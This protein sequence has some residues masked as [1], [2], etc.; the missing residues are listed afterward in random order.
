MEELVQFIEQTP[1]ASLASHWKEMLH[2]LP[3][4]LCDSAKPRSWKH[5][6]NMAAVNSSLARVQMVGYDQKLVSKNFCL[7][8]YLLPFVV[9][10]LFAFLNRMFMEPFK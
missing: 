7:H 6:Y 10:H 3:P 1:K 5:L 2:F 4:P 9:Y 8:S